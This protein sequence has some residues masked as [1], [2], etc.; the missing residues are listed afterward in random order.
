VAG[1]HGDRHPA[2][3]G[4]IGHVTLRIPIHA[5]TERESFEIP[6][7]YTVIEPGDAELVEHDLPVGWH[8]SMRE[9]LSES[10]ITVGPWTDEHIAAACTRPAASVASADSVAHTTTDSIAVFTE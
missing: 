6:Q 5:Y 8:G 3:D 7:T 10:G 1:N 4:I 2:Q 9:M